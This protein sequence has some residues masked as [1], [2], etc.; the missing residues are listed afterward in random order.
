MV[1]II[2]GG[3]AG[4]STA[5]H[6]GDRPHLVLEG[7]AV[8]AGL[9]ASGLTFLQIAAVIEALL[10]FGVP[11]PQASQYRQRRILFN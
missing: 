2:G 1:V 6:L 8:F 11:R 7:I 3:L 5:Y 9:V 4:M 10:W